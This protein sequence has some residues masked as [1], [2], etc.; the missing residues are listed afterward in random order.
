VGQ[1]VKV[2]EDIEPLNI[3]DWNII[4]THVIGKIFTV[5]EV[6]KSDTLFYVLKGLRIDISHDWLLPILEEEC[7]CRKL[8]NNQLIIVNNDG[9]CVKCGAQMSIKTI[10]TVN[11]VLAGLSDEDKEIIRGRLR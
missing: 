11:D 10:R 3:D 2:R 5:E 9:C 1:K 4:K 8:V 6:K 7:S